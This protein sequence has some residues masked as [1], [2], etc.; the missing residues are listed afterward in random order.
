MGVVFLNMYL[1]SCGYGPILYLYLGK[2]WDNW[3]DD[4]EDQV[5]ADEDLVLCAVIWLSVV[6]VEKHHS[7]DS[8]GVVE[9]S[10]GQQACHLHNH[11]L[12]VIA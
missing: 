4:A 7:S 9:D 3:N 8:Q 10:E 11:M 5:E 6:N 1:Y 12:N 2:D